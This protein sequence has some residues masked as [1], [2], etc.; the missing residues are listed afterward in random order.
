LSYNLIED[1]SPISGL[2][3][4]EGLSYWGAESVTDFSALAGL[5]NMLDICIAGNQGNG[6]KFNN[7]DM[8]NLAGMKKNVDYTG[9]SD[10]SAAAEIIS[11]VEM[12]LTGSKVRDVSPLKNL[13]NLKK[14]LLKDC[15]VTDYAPLKG[16]YPNLEEKDFKL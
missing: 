8:Q 4:I 6:I 2:T 9:V 16:I 5:T 13:V 15:P 12:D 7:N 3:Q 11:L 14:L 10:V 1:L